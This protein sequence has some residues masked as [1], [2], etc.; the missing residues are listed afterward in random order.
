M[1]RLVISIFLFL[2][3]ASA[4]SGQDII[5][6]KDGSDI[7]AKVLE[8][9]VNDVQYKKFNNQDGPS[10]TIAKSDILMITYE[11]GER[12]VF[13]E[14]NNKLPEG[15]MT[16]D[17][18]TGRLSINGMNIDKKSTF[19]YFSPETEALY[20]SGD[21]LSTVGEI[22]IGAGCGAALGYLISSYAMTRTAGNG[23]MYAVCGG[24]VAA[25]I[26]ML[27]VGLNKINTAIADYNTKHGYASCPP[28]VNFGLQNNGIGLALRF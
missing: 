2:S 25:G 20:K 1:E 18:W 26:P 17:A 19:R 7:Q 13:S 23:V 16:L 6:K 21:A 9:G 14:S 27:V 28:E 4:L 24:V 3:A 22:L 5:T 12:D 10:F 8:V 15:I 11:N